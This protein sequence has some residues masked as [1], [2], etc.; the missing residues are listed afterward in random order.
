MYPHSNGSAEC[1]VQTVE[2]ILNKCDEEAEN[3]YLGLLSYHTEPVSSNLKSPAELL[4]NHK[5]RTSLPMS[6]CVIVNETNSKTKEELYQGQK[7]QA[8]F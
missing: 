1:M 7:L 6:K 3:R 2:N 8:F 5:L 4:N